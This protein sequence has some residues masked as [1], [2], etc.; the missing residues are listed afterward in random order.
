MLYRNSASWCL[1]DPP[2]HCCEGVLAR[3]QTFISPAVTGPRGGLCKL[4]GSI[5]SWGKFDTWTVDQS[6]VL[7]V[8]SIPNIYRE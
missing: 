8:T 1:A 7:L 5:K 6:R 2:P 4:V 3:P